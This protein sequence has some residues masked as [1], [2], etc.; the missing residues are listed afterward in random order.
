MTT[1]TYATKRPVPFLSTLLL[2]LV[3]LVLPGQTAWAQSG[4]G[5]LTLENSTRQNICEFYISGSTDS[6]WGQ[7]QL[8]GQL[9]PGETATWELDA[10][11]YDLQTVDCSGTILDEYYGFDIRRGDQRVYTVGQDD[12]S[13]EEEPT[14]DAIDEE[15]IP[16]NA[17]AEE[18]EIETVSGDDMAMQDL[19]N[20]IA[21]DLDAYW[22]GVFSEEGSSYQRPDVHLYDKDSLRTSCGGISADMGP[23]Y[24]SLD[25]T[26][27]LP[28]YFMEEVRQAI[29]DFSVATVIAH[30]WG[31]AVQAMFGVETQYS[32]VQE[33]RADCF[34][35]SYGDYIENDSDLITLEEG[36]L[37]EGATL[38]YEIGDPRSVE[39]FDPRA[40]GQPDQRSEAYD[41][42][43]S[44][45]E[46]C[47]G[48]DA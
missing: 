37:D 17:P 6:D 8:D 5:T 13:Q 33:L 19:V 30:E 14:P 9:A 35:G 32:I 7:N 39:W 46:G 38:L 10:G 36:D 31:H 26:I 43:L 11:L 42:G 44:G 27:Y 45:Y 28:Y 23:L 22:T 15:E 24:C 20:L 1:H 21:E 18:P 47:W 3:F 25:H 16:A 2:L 41:L 34:A 12:V 29:G 48:I 40:H 4:G